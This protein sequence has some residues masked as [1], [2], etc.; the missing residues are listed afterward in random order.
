MALGLLALILVLW[1][2]IRSCGSAV[3]LEES[4]GGVRDVELTDVY[5]QDA[6]ADVTS[7]PDVKIVKKSKKKKKRYKP[8][9]KVDP[10][11]IDVYV[12]SSAS[13]TLGRLFKK[14]IL[15]RRKNLR[16]VSSKPKRGRMVTLTAS[17]RKRQKGK[18]LSLKVNC[19]M[20]LSKI[21]GGL[22][23]STKASANLE[24]ENGEASDLPV[25]QRQA[26]PACAHELA[27]D[28]LKQVK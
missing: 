20:S 13:R 6:S 19:K 28:F 7:A 27:N 2:L 10:N 26:L 23:A 22:I 3:V 12:H 25:L 24:M 17:A 1:A 15:S 18:V 8:R 4:D 14:R 11:M 16:F 21:P 5:A 9:A